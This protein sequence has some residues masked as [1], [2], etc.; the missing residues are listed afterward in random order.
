MNAVQHIVAGSGSKG[1]LAVSWVEA[2]EN[3]AMDALD[4]YGRP[5]TPLVTS[6]NNVLS[7]KDIAISNIAGYCAKMRVRNCPCPPVPL[8]PSRRTRVYQEAS[9]QLSP[10]RLGAAHSIVRAAPRRYPCITS[11]KAHY[12]NLGAVVTVYDH[13]RRLGGTREGDM[14]ANQVVL[15]QLAA[16]AGEGHTGA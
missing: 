12:V 14:A 7:D 10:F 6:P 4:F 15:I 16:R 5:C 2:G 11:D 1:F 9:Q 8:P 3:G 13:G